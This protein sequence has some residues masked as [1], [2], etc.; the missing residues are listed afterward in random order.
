MDF[1]REALGHS[2][3]ATTKVHLDTFEQTE[4]DNI[5]KHLI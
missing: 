2:N 5:F 4:M 1:I 3:E